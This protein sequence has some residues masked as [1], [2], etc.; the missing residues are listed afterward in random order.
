[1]KLWDFLQ[2]VKID[3]KQGIGEV[4]DNN[5][6]DYL[7]LRVLMRPSVFL[8]L[9]STLYREQASSVDYIKQQLAQGRG[10]ASPWLVIDIP[11]A[12]GQNNLDAPARVVSHEGRNRMYAVLETEGD[13]PI[14]THLFFSGG[15]RN[16]HIKPNW[17]ENMNKSLVPQRSNQRVP[18]PFFQTLNQQPNTLSEETAEQRATYRA[19][20]R[21]RLG[22]YDPN[23]FDVEEDSLED[24][25]GQV[26]AVKDVLRPKR[27]L[28]SK[29]SFEPNPQL[30]YRGMSNAEFENIKKTGVIKSKGDYNLQGQ[31]GLTYF[32]TRP[33]TA[34]SYAH[35]FAPWSQKAN[36]DKP[37]WVIAVPK[38]DPSQIVHVPGT[39]SHEVGVKGVINADQIKEIYRGK[40][41]EYDPGVPN[42]VAPSAWLHWEKVPVK[43]V[44]TE[45]NG[46]PGTLKAKISKRYGGSVTCAKA[47]KLKS[48]KTS[49]ALDKRQANWFLNMQDCNESQGVQP[50]TELVSLP[51]TPVEWKQQQFNFGRRYLTAF[52]LD[53]H[54]VE[55]RM[56]QDRSH[57]AL[58]NAM[59]LDP[60][61]INPQA[62]GYTILFMVDDEIIKTGLLGQKSSTLLAQTFGRILQWL[63]T[64]KWDYIIFTGARGSRNK[65]Y[66][67]ISRQLAREFGAKLHFDFDTSDFVVY[68]PSTFA[69]KLVREAL[70]WQLPSNNWTVQSKYDRDITYK[71]AVDGEKYFMEIVNIPEPNNRGIYDIEFFHEEHGMDITGLGV[72]HAMKVFSA[73]KQLARDAQGRLT[74]LPIN[75][76]FFSGRGASRQKLYL[77][78]AQQLAEEMGWKLT[79]TRALM[80]LQGDSNMQGYLIYSP[81][82]ENRILNPKLRDIQEAESAGSAL[83]I[84]DIDSTLMKTSAAVYVVNTQ[85]K[86]A[87]LT[88]QDFNSY[89]LKPGEYFDFQEFEDSDLFHDTSE[90]IAQIWR[91]AQN[92]LANTGRRPGSRVV[93]ITAR[94]PFNNTE[95]FLKTFEKHGLDMTKVRV[96]TV[97]GARNKKPLIRQLLQQ[98]NYTETRIFDDHLGNLR[99]FLSLH[100]EFPQ[101]TFKAFAV[102]AAGTVGQPVVIQGT[103]DE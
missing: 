67:M 19:S 2:E 27:N 31:E 11:Q 92:T 61:Q 82:I 13:E 30:V 90:P 42:Q 39:G 94:G 18:G 53:N 86:R 12:W 60:I 10:I 52:E 17:I 89:Q 38:P 93:I 16:R 63:K 1:M 69:Q 95:K 73:V 5:N 65:L 33:E 48:R 24:E 44:V 77:R 47:K 23:F 87:K 99:D 70:T 49:T 28:N 15:L 14:E 101:V 81:K 51:K 54:L 20:W 59:L 58:Q 4:P 80:P 26:I 100:P 37:A 36:W 98:H 41:V 75:A 8:G 85:G 66:G 7:G 76:W 46:A 62:H 55:I 88:A 83:T 32:T 3:N 78:L 22:E 50:I 29:L 45:R 84:F 72:S 103:T 71:F 6:V 57:Y 21:G 9:A 96:F 56:D 25:K 97:G 68:K 34:D 43:I 35:S 91:T 79:T 74:D 64:H 40:V 102:G